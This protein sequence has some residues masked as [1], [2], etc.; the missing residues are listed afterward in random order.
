MTYDD[1]FHRK[2]V[3]RA[4]QGHLAERGSVES[5][6]KMPQTIED[7]KRYLRH[8]EISQNGNWEN[9]LKSMIFSL[10]RWILFKKVDERDLPD[11]QSELD[12]A[13]D[14]NS[15]LPKLIDEIVA[16]VKA[17]RS[18]DRSVG[19]LNAEVIGIGVKVLKNA[20][21]K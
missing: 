18:A 7:L 14:T 21:K 13:I 3:I 4:S 6:V 8:P 12:R 17:R 5:G 19:E 20:K 9:D 1:I 15:E 2:G 16:D 11:F 10:V